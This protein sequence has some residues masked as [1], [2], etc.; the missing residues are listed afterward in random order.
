M[1][2]KGCLAAGAICACALGNAYLS[3]RFEA[4]ACGEFPGPAIIHLSQSFCALPP[5][6]LPHDEPGNMPGP[7]LANLKLAVSTSSA[8]AT[9]FVLNLPLATST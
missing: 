1:P 5:F 8:S 4:V 3:G 2:C 7:P 9:T 6:D